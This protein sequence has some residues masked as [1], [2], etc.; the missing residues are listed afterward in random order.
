[1]IDYIQATD[2]EHTAITKE[3]YVTGTGVVLPTSLDI[4]VIETAANDLDELMKKYGAPAANSRCIIELRSYRR[5]SV[6]DSSATA[7]WSRASGHF[8]ALEVSFNESGPLKDIRSDTKALMDKVRAT[9][10]SR[11]PGAGELFNANLGGGMDKAQEM[12]GGNYPKLRELK[13]KYDPGFVFD[14]WYPIQPAE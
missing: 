8:L 10:K 6:V 3:T 11:N 14:K 2:P 1:M 7:Y 9:V 5:S 12:F 4:D 13:K